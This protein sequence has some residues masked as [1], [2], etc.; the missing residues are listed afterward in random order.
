MTKLLFPFFLALVLLSGCNKNDQDVKF[1]MAY[2]R[3]FT[4][5]AG[6]NTFQTHY[7]YLRDIPIGTYLSNNN[8]QASDL[9]AINPGAARLS[10]I[11]TGLTD[12]SFI[13]DVSIKIFTDDETNA[14]EIFWRPD[15]PLN[16]GE[17][18]DV[19][20]TLIDAKQFLGNT[21]FNV[22]IKLNIR[23]V[24]QQTI[25]TKFRFSFLAK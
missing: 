11:F 14:R 2:E 5:P 22:F 20:A 3:N 23:A 4:I 12:Y 15:I 17:D 18:L 8:V 7:I 19:F 9:M 13:R 24:P 25:D 6:L 21:K 16:T 1:E 10:T